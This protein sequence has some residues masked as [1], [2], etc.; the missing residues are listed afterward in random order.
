[1]LESIGNV[2]FK[3]FFFFQFHTMNISLILVLMLFYYFTLL[4]ET[5]GMEIFFSYKFIV[6]LR[7]WSLVSVKYIH[8]YMYIFKHP[9]FF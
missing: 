2:D 5:V 3:Y 1:M 8:I 7:I 4:F 6:I 9:V